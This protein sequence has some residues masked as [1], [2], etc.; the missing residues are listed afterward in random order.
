[1][2]L[3]QTGFVSSQ[4]KPAEIYSK[5][6][7]SDGLTKVDNRLGFDQEPRDRTYGGQ[8]FP[9]LFKALGVLRHGSTFM[10]VCGNNALYQGW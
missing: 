8:G 6:G 3:E 1:M 9:W 4:A 10:N 7:L 5:K 2:A